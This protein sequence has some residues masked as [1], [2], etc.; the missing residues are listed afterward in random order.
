[1]ASLAPA[2]TRR[3]R[4]RAGFA[5]LEDWRH[6]TARTKRYPATF[7]LNLFGIRRLL[8]R[9]HLE[10]GKWGGSIAVSHDKWGYGAN[11]KRAIQASDRLPAAAGPVTLFRVY[12]KHLSL[13]RRRHASGRG[14]AASYETAK[15]L[16]QDA[17]RRPKRSPATGVRFA[18]HLLGFD[19]NTEG[20][21][22]AY[23]AGIA[24]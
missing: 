20:G 5:T 3:V 17:T 24:V 9:N 10:L 23:F 12:I 21:R 13:V 6:P 1:M 16:L 2:Q 8:R 14:V 18:L 15:Q 22:F 11:A 4:R 7:Y 19:K